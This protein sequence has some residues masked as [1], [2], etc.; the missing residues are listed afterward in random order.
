M[1]PPESLTIALFPDVPVSVST[2]KAVGAEVSPPGIDLFVIVIDTESI[3]SLFA[4][5]LRKLTAKVAAVVLSDNTVVVVV[6]L[7]A[8]SVKLLGTTIAC[9][10][11][12]LRTLRPKAAVATSA[13]RLKFVFVDIISFR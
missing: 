10:G 4:D 2:N 11:T 13:T 12:E 5:E 8:V 1:P 6:E 7:V 3:Q 9:D